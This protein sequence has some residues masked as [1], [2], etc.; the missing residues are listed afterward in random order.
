M[1]IRES[2]FEKVN[3]FWLMKTNFKAFFLLVETIIEIR[4][5]SFF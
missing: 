2:S 5:N 4:G 1:E 3:L